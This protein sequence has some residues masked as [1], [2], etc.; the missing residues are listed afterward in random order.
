MLWSSCL[1]G[2]WN[3]PENYL[4]LLT[5]LKRNWIFSKT[6]GRNGIFWAQILIERAD[7][8]HPNGDGY[9]RDLAPFRHFRS[10]T[11]TSTGTQ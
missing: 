2:I 9:I 11:G 4:I 10:I 3:V 7:S 8:A 6:F 1:L 5:T